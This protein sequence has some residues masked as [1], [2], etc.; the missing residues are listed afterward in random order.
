MMSRRPNAVAKDVP[1]ELRHKIIPA[2]RGFD[3]VTHQGYVLKSFAT[4]Q[5]ASDYYAYHCPA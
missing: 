5:E 1:P 2:A 4:E 3:L